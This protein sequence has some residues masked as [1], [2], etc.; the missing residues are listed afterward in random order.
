MADVKW[1]KIVVD[2]FDD[3]K[4]LLIMS[5]PEA[6]KIII[7]WIKLLCSAGRQ[8]NSGVFK[9][10]NGMPYTVKMLSTIF[11]MDEATVSLAFNTFESFGMI[12]IVKDV[13]T[14]TNWGKH[15]NLDKIEAY[16]E[17]QRNYMKEYRA[18]QKAIAA[19][20]EQRKPKGKPNS[21]PKIS[22]ADGDIELDKDKNIDVDKS[23]DINTDNSESDKKNISSEILDYQ[24]ILDFYHSTCKTLPKVVK[25]T[26]ERKAA[27]CAAVEVLD[28]V[29]FE[30]LFAKVA[31]SDFLM[32]R[33]KDWRAD[34]D[35][36]LRSENI[37]KILSGK[38]HGK[39]T[40]SAVDYSDTSRYDNLTMGVD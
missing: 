4:I 25:L 12:Q 39:A 16:N 14:I 24:H 40:K 28:G 9:L 2:L 34:F 20:E 27:M 36:I 3:E 17:Y 6:D 29:S 23:Q 5:M 26:D 11:R 32:G 15:Q 22:S 33:V 1:I 21:K 19:G 30:Q 38:Y 31:N 18:K 37:V 7:I 35:W 8:N 13:I 10:S